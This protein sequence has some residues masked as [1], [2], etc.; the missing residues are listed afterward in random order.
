MSVLPFPTSLDYSAA[1]AVRGDAVLVTLAGELDVAM[2]P[3]VED[4]L[5]TAIDLAGHVVVVDLSLVT[6]LDS[7]GLLALTRAR[8][9]AF[10]SGV[11]LV[12]AAPSDQVARLLSLIGGDQ[13]MPTFG[14]VATAVHRYSRTRPDPEPAPKRVLCPVGVA[15]G[16]G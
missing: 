16:H 7:N 2:A 14:S 13:V 4:H 5:S 11:A 15:A 6:F 9:S 1:I 10:L 8:S 12:C 3:R